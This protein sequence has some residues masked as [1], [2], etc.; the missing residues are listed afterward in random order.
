MSQEPSFFSDERQLI[1]G[2]CLFKFYQVEDLDA[3]KN[4]L[5]QGKEMQDHLTIKG[6][7]EHNLKNIDVTLPR[8]SLTVI[9]GVSGSGKSSLAYD[10][11]FKEGQ[12]R[13]VESL[14]PYARQFLGQMEKPKVNSI[15]G[16]SPAIC[17]D[18]KRR[19]Q[20]SRSTV[21]TI[22]EIYD[23]LRLMF[24]RLG[25]PHC[26]ECGE[27]IV[28]QTPDQIARFIL[29]HYENRK[30]YVLAPMVMERKGEYRKELAQWYEDGF[31]RVRID[32]KIHRLDEEIKL[33]RY[34]KHTLE[35]V[36]DRLIVKNELRGR[37]CDDIEQATRQTEGLVAFWVDEEEY[38]LFSVHRACPSCGI[39]LPE[40]E[41]RL[42]SFNNNQGAC[43]GC[44]GRGTR[45]EFDLT[46]IV[47]DPNKSI[48][49]G[50][51]ACVKE[52]DGFIIFSN[53]GMEDFSALAE[54]YDL[55][56]E[57]PWKDLPFSFQEAIL[58]GK[59][60]AKNI[61]FAGVIP[62][63][64]RIYF[65]WRLHQFRRFLR[66]SP[67]PDC[68]GARLRKESLSVF[69][70]GKNIAELSSMT[71]EDLFTFLQK[72]K[73][74]SE[75]KMVGKEIF[76]ELNGRL[77][78]LDDVG[79]DYLTLD[80]T[81]NTLAGGEMQ[82]IRLARQ[83]GSGLQGVL[84]IL[85]EPSIGLHASDNT[86]LLK[87]LRKLR[88]TGNTVV[89]IEH[90]E[91]TIRSADHIIDIG[92]GAGNEGGHLVAAGKVT[93][94]KNAPDS[95]TGKYLSK[96]KE[97]AWPG[98]RRLPSDQWLKIVQATEHNLKNIDVE[99]PLGLFVVI[100]GVSGSG[101]STLAEDILCKA[102]SQHF[103]GSSQ[104]PGKHKEI[105]GL[106][107]IDKVIR[108]DQSPI[109]R[110]PRSN[111]VTY[112]KVFDEIRSLFTLLPESKMR[113]YLPGRFSFNVQGG[114]CEE[115]KGA[116]VKEIEMQFLSNVLITCEV[117]DGKR[118]NRETLEVVYKHKNIS[119]ILT[120]TIAEACDFFTHIPKIHHTLSTLCE[121]GLGY[122]QMGQPSPTLSGGEAQ[123]I[124]LVRELRRPD[125]G[126]TFYLLDEPT[127]GL[128]FRDIENLLAALDRLVKKGNTV[129]VIEHNLDIIKCADY[130]IDMG[131]LGGKGGG[132]VVASGSPEEIMAS[133]VS[134]TGKSLREYQD[135]DHRLVRSGRKK[136]NVGSDIHIH[137][138]MKNNLKNVSVVIPKEKMTVITGVSG[139]GKT[140]LA[141]DTLFA[142]GQR[143][144]LESLS[145]YARRFLGRLDHGDVDYIEG[146]APA[147]A[148]DQK[149]A[150]RNPRSTVATMTEI[151][152]Y[153]RILY[154]RAG[155][156]HCPEC[157][158]ELTPHTASSAAD[159]VIKRFS[160]KMGYILAPLYMPSTLKTYALHKSSQ[161]K[162]QIPYYEEQGFTRILME[163]KVYRFDEEI[164]SKRAPIHL[165]IDR[166]K[167][168]SKARA[169]IAESF[170][171]AFE[172]GHQVALCHV[173]SE[174][175]ECYSTL[176]AC[177]PCDY[178]QDQ[179][180]H[181]RM[182]SFNHYLGSCPTCDGLGYLSSDVED[183]CFD[184]QGQR[185][186][187]EFLAVRMGDTSI[188][189]L[190]LMKVHE[191]QSFLSQLKLN[192]NQS[193]IARDVL[194]EIRNRLKFLEDV[195]LSY[196]TLER[197]GNTLSGGEAQRIRLASQ[198]G[199]QLVGVLY[200][201]DEPTIGLH[202]RD[203]DKLLHTLRKLVAM[204]NTIVMVEHDPQ[205][206]RQADHVIDMGPGAGHLG[207]EVVAEGS[208]HQISQQ[209]DSLT[210][211]YLSGKLVIPVMRKR[212]ISSKSLQVKNASLHNLK[213][214][215]I[216][217]PLGCFNVVTGVSGSGKSSLVIDILQ[218]TLENRWKG[219]SSVRARSN[220]GFDSI[221]GLSSLERLVVIDQT[222]IGRSPN[223]NP[224]TYTGIFDDIRKFYAR[225]PGSK[226]RG[227][228]PGRFSFN[229]AGGRC[230]A[231]EGKGVIKVNMHFL[232]DVW[233]T[234]QACKGQRYLE[235]T[236]A[237]L[238]QGKN[239]AQVLEMDIQQALEFFSSH[240]KISHKLEM[241][242]D[243]G[244]GYMKL[245]QPGTTLSG[246]EAQRI[247]LTTELAT[248]SR[249]N[250]LYLL[251][252]PTTG[253]HYADIEKLLEVLHRLVD[254]GNTV[255]V[256]EHNIEVIQSADWM[257]DLGPE[258]G[259]AGGE[260]VYAGPP[261]KSANDC[262]SSHTG[263]YLRA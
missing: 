25:I 208:P 91:E 56:L 37:I 125:T 115:C 240:K 108:V 120:M 185:L 40:M 226:T 10:T 35:L 191:A 253:L 144:F 45:E 146:L 41:P 112:T 162:E 168:T 27:K 153:F 199:N 63:M 6:A 182:F 241:L 26:Y 21:G 238:Y 156:P 57:T 152:D 250:T 15:E 23:H 164:P 204:G 194:R 190:C 245:G 54:L 79:L 89:V 51:L 248:A 169:R 170:E 186:K 202:Q 221:T 171:V 140:S 71:V 161:L 42:F 123:R 175:P 136:I 157:S 158:Q 246:G 151:Y 227:F 219:T 231:C 55:S 198:I 244:L 195:G 224:A 197:R 60:K 48:S 212:M 99:V 32:G 214:I 159:N 254:E 106:E 94:I 107:H 13:F 88:N 9:T 67:C 148:I 233:I 53:Q 83:L 92:P 218:N 188:S 138:G 173:D 77:R 105:L 36:L 255:I 72:V 260:V 261:E 49:E 243:V 119:D 124:K 203:T 181:P 166:V 17:I 196:L 242:V 19:G 12:R 90:D 127:T 16:I 251:D 189:Q 234:C 114:R 177:V 52:K 230:E 7:R 73:L 145:T 86:R 81:A 247:K 101:K 167:I 59:G 258:G 141:F 122:L 180:L 80:R 121:V 263:K 30:V 201:L 61:A 143:S 82:R 222:P 135:G 126:K 129:L 174:L 74:S 137:G 184:C 133:K 205:C 104:I 215:D 103:Q 262:P 11:L 178:F 256:I 78:F 110:T 142:E 46:L 22:T 139:S 109:G 62:L 95:L 24:A 14:S 18:Q 58:N 130:I 50:A 66:I 209:K 117:C 4:Y 207:G 85:D 257:I 252:E 213:N 75:E 165:I 97:I 216:S 38:R 93:Q 87:A 163:G 128:H 217:F 34:E 228:K 28:S 225:L 8:H 39:S 43:S 249:S 116:G 69:F 102:L 236:L 96:E 5:E 3:T 229:R 31:I 2:F 239:I 206:I 179:E 210:G 172:V 160:G 192:K 176:P 33:E 47:P 131:P 193:L 223:S 200:V 98:E 64:E 113:G 147:I 1:Q 44:L 187:P 20:S 154:S 84:Y 65:K 149:N 76:K 68:Q 70:Q 259:D 220:D 235:E 155:I 100:S 118:F 237:V 29:S 134:A 211:A 132:E 232:S 111:P 150:S 183:I